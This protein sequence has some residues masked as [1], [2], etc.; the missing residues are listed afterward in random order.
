LIQLNDKRRSRFTLATIQQLE[1]VGSYIGSLIVHQREATE[2]KNLEAHLYQAQRLE[3]VG[4]LAGG[5]AHDFKNMLTVILGYTQLALAEKD[6][7]PKIHEWL[8]EVEK[9][10]VHSAN[11]TNQLLTF[12]RRQPT[13]PVIINLNEVVPETLGMLQKLIGDDIRLTWGPVSD[14]WSLRCDP[15]HISTILTNLCINS[16]DAISNSGTIHIEVENCTINN[17]NNKN[18]LG[19]FVGD[20]VRISV[21]DN[22]S[23]MSQETVNLIFDP[24]FTTKEIGKGTGL[25]LSIVFGIVKQNNGFIEVHSD[26]GVG[27]TFLIHLPRFTGVQNPTNNHIAPS[28]QVVCNESI[29]LVEDEVSILNML[30]AILTKQGYTVIRANNPEKAILLAKEHDGEISLIVTDVIMPTMNGYDLSKKLTED[31][32][33]LKCLFM[34]GYTADVLADHGVEDSGLF[35]IQKPFGLNSFVCKVREVLD[36][37]QACWVGMKQYFTSN[38]PIS[39]EI[40]VLT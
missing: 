31:Y 29:L 32:P 10:T 16:R 9:A 3:S 37:K 25:G 40:D 24:F 19:A 15:S 1:I 27:T 11:L 8:N 26:F 21:K 33:K 5:I 38:A 20:Y 13:D 14:L 12:A 28:P 17:I 34:S 7:T 2:K 4:L 35:F 22:G 39:S 23:G 18:N 6:S 36:S 30:A